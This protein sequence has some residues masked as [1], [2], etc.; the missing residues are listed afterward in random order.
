MQ[1]FVDGTLATPGGGLWPEY[2]IPEPRDYGDPVNDHWSHPQEDHFFLWE[3]PVAFYGREL[4]FTPLDREPDPSQNPFG[5]SEYGR[6]DWWY[7]FVGD[8]HIQRMCVLIQ[9]QTGSAD[10]ADLFLT[11]SLGEPLEAERVPGEDWQWLV[12][13][14]PPG[15]QIFYIWAA[16]KNITTEFG[17][18]W[19]TAGECSW[20][21]TPPET[22]GVLQGETSSLAVPAPLLLGA[23][24]P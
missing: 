4:A 24:I 5:S 16:P 14:M 13:D 15:P 20:F 6:G 19:L 10:E 9:H 3:S 21:A 23:G 2:R 17:R 22:A 7:V 18:Y 8:G 1:V 11:T 12:M